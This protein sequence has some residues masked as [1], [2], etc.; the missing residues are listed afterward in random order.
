MQYVV[1]QVLCYGQKLLE[2]IKDFWVEKSHPSDQNCF[3][4]WAL[5][6]R[7]PSAMH[8][9]AF[10]HTTK[11]TDVL[12]G[13]M[14]MLP[15][16]SRSYI[17]LY[18]KLGVEDA[19]VDPSLVSNQRVDGWLHVKRKAWSQPLARLAGERFPHCCAKRD[20]RVC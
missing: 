9:V 8:S 5:K 16:H 17:V 4:F 15:L 2:W 13:E 1:R 11:E 6:P 10:Y 7:I 18:R 20:H 12:G 14:A 3:A 19:C